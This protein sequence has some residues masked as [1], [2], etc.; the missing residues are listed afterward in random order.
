MPAHQA[1]TLAERLQALREALDQA[2]QAHT[3]QPVTPDQRELLKQQIIALFR[4]A[5]AALQQAQAMKEA[6]KGLADQWKH[7]DGR[8][9]G[10]VP[11]A[12]AEVHRPTPVASTT[13]SATT[14][15]VDHLG[16]STFLEKGWSKLAL[17]DAPGAEAAFRRAL[18]LA[19]G[20]LE[21]QSLLCWAQ[22]QQ[23]NYD[24][25]LLTL[26]SVLSLDP[27]NALAHA[28]L[29]Y[30]CLRRKA[31]GEAI[32]HLSTVIRADADR[33]AVLYAHLY[34]GMVYRER[35][36]YDDAEAFFMRALELGPNLLQAWYELGRA[37]WF[38]GRPD[39]ARQAWKTGSEANKFSPWGKRC[40]EVLQMVEQG[41][42]PSREG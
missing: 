26:Q 4:E 3:L 5:D 22:M 13:V 33:R 9:V 23:E 39:E 29:G 20:S 16:A 1:Y 25:A 12:G 17:L 7:L 10:T 28:N 21:A 15:R 32:E 18:D 37:R 34:L 2:C 42:A 36:M 24:A 19:P 35:E 14:G 31:Y 27:H 30:I 41:G 40:A 6:V 8:G 38:A 11:G